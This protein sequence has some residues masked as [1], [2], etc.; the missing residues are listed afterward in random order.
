MH[1][2]TRFTCSESLSFRLKRKPFLYQK[3]KKKRELK[4]KPIETNLSCDL[5]V[6]VRKHKNHGQPSKEEKT[7]LENQA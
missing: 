6:D 5:H 3:K 2:L 4:R 1:G 7:Q